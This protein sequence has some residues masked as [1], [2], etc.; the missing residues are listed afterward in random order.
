MLGRWLELRPGSHTG[1]RITGIT[2][3]RYPR[4]NPRRDEFLQPA[5]L[6][7]EHFTAIVS[8]VYILFLKPDGF[9]EHFSYIFLPLIRQ[10]VEPPHHIRRNEKRA[11]AHNVPPVVTHRTPRTVSNTRTVTPDYRLAAL[12][13]QRLKLTQN[14]YSQRMRPRTADYAAAAVFSVLFAVGGIVIAVLSPHEADVLRLWASTNVTNLR[15]HPIPALVVSAFLPSG[16]PFAWLVPIALTMFA[17]NR[18]VGTARLALICTAGHLI[19]TGVSEGI[20]AYRVDHGSLPPTWSHIFDVGPS[21]V[22]V[23]AIV[24]VVMFGTGLARVTALAVFAV[25]VFVSHIFAGLTSLQVAAVGHLTAMVTAAALGLVLGRSS[26]SGRSR[27]V[28]SPGRVLLPRNGPE[29]GAS[30]RYCGCGC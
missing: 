19:G 6:R 24:L 21:Y 14:A 17:A 20:V 18:A 29:P 1:A 28:A 30:Y 2:L 16:W 4:A 13:D 26:G 27:A 8:D 10:I 11:F 12:R 5:V 25:L 23:S 7:D 15:H 22:V 3:R 9:R